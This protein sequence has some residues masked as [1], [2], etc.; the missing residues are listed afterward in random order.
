MPPQERDQANGQA[1]DY[2]ADQ[3]VDYAGGLVRV[4]VPEAAERLGIS[5]NAL[6]K[7]VQRDTVPWERDADGRVFVY[8]PPAGTDQAD[9]QAG[10][11][12]TDYA[13]GMAGD[14]AGDQAVV[15][16]ELVESL[17]EQV[18][19]LRGALDTRDK[20]LA[21]MRRLL[22]GALE[23]IPALEAPSD[24]P[25]EL[26]ES[27]QAP[28]ENGGDGRHDHTDTEAYKPSWW[29]RFFGLE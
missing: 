18:G 20:E 6:R 26:R 21:E 17:Q 11:Q 19:Y 4:T 28:S 29:R 27:P 9:D 22:A 8:L 23:R 3:A 24:T 15:P 12:A 1:T 13:A 2:A 7:R 25:P 16:A 14:Q 10:D 5:E